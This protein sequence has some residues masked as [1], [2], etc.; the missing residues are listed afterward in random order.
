MIRIC[1]AQR[2]SLQHSGHDLRR[3]VLVL[4]QLEPCLKEIETF[5]GELRAD[6]VTKCTGSIGVTAADGIA[7]ATDPK[8]I[9]LPRTQPAMGHLGTCTGKVYE[10]QSLAYLK[11]C[12]NAR[13][14]TRTCPWNVVVPGV[15]L[16]NTEGAYASLPGNSL[17][18]PRAHCE[19][20][21]SRWNHQP[22]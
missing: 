1:R 20:R 15:D 3:L 11:F 5:S 7:K 10:T 4:K 19:S 12:T 17:L 18:R 2:P 14:L 21:L 22:K 8:S 6:L 13:K 16:P 9:G